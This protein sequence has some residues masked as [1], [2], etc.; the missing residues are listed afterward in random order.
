MRGT[1]EAHGHLIGTVLRTSLA[2]SVGERSIAFSTRAIGVAV[3][4][5]YRRD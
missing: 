4:I 5:G 1:A 3:R 2:H